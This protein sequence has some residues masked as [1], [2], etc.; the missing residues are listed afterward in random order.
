MFLLGFLWVL[1]GILVDLFWDP[2]GFLAGS[3]Q[4]VVS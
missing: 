3:L 2:C 1:A 4:D